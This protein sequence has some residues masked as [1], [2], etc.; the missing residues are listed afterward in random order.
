MFA[1]A[2]P[3][4]RT[5]Q[6]FINFADNGFLDSQGFTPFGQITSGM[7]VVKSLYSGY[8]EKPDQGAIRLREKLTSTR[9][10][11]RLTAFNPPR[12]FRPRHSRSVANHA[13]SD[14]P[15]PGDNGRWPAF[16]WPV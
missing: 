15:A 13:T 16:H 3:N 12:F 11:R 2:G 6:L 7:D 5:T 1:T 9:I 14:G 8:G 10:S 4:T